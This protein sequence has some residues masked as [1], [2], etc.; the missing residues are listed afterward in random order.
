M[1]WFDVTLVILEK[2]QNRNSF[3]SSFNEHLMTID[4]KLDIEEGEFIC[5]N[6][7]Q[8][9]EEKEVTDLHNRMKT[10]DVLTLLSQWPGLGILSY[11]HP[12]FSHYITINYLT[13][14]D[15]LIYGFTIGFNGKE[16]C[17]DPKKQQS[18]LLI[19]KICQLVNYRCAVGNIDNISDTY[20]D[21]SSELSSI[22][23]YIEKT[24]FELDKRKNT[25]N[26]N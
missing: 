2:A 23:K 1:G 10:E 6:D 7:T 15:N 25:T 13:W 5:Y 16:V 11:R 18:R 21:T 12:G 9:G 19:D 24:T 17:L 20:I 3:L 22:L 14:D 26:F 4:V 8:A